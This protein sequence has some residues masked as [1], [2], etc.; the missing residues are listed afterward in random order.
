MNMAKDRLKGRKTLQVTNFLDEFEKDDIKKDVDIV[1]LFEHFGVNLT[2]K[3]KSYM[4]SCPW[5]ED[6]TPSLSVDRD[7]GLYNCFGCGESGDIFS[8]T[9]KMKGLNFRESVT[10]LKDF[11]GTTPGKIAD[12]NSSTNEDIPPKNLTASRPQ[13]EQENNV[14]TKDK[15][16]STSEETRRDAEPLTAET[17]EQSTSDDVSPTAGAMTLHTVTDYYHKRLFDNPKALDYLKNRG[18]ADTKLFTRFQIG[19]ADGTI[20]EKLTDTQKQSLKQQGIITAKD[21]EHFNDCVTI[22]IFDDLDT[23]VG[24]YG[25]SINP[26]AKIPHLYLKGKH[27]SVFN[28][29]AS[30]VYDEI[31]LTESIVDALS[32]ISLGFENTQSI[33]GTNGFTDEHLTILKDDRVKTVICAFDNDEAGEKASAKLKEQ[34]ANEGFVVKIISLPQV[35]NMFPEHPDSTV[36]DWNEYLTTGGTKEKITK[37]IDTADVFTPEQEDAHVKAEKDTLGHVFTINDIA[38]RVTG[39]KEL[40]I[41]NLRVNIK[42][43]DADTGLK[44]YDNLDLYSARSRSGYAG[45]MGRTLDIEPNR[46]EK[47]L[48]A[49]LEYL[50]TERDRH[51]KS[52]TGKEQETELTPEERELGL[53]FLKSPEMFAEIVE[54]MDV[55]GYVGE[56]LNKQL[57]YIAATSR[58]LDDPISVMVVS[59]SASGKSLLIDTIARLIPSD[60]VIS[61]TSL[62]EQALNYME[63][64]SHK[65][66]SLGEIVHSE[67]VEH[68]IREMLSKKELSRL[69]TTKEAQSGK[70]ITRMVKIPALVSLAMSGTRY[71]MNPENTSRCFMV[72]A[73]ESREQ[74]RRIH[75]QQWTKKYSVERKNE[76]KELIPE[77]I[78]KHHA[79]QK[80]LQPITIENTFGEYLDFPNTLMRTR[81][82]N[83]RFVDLIACVCFLRQYQKEQKYDANNEP[84]I[85]FDLIDYEIAYRIMTSGVLSSSLLEIPRGALDLY[86]YFRELARK[87]AKKENIEAREVSLTQREIREYTGLNQV[88]VK[89]HIKILLDYEYIA[90]ARGGKA[91]S[92]GHYQLREDVPMEEV[93]LSMIPTPEELKQKIQGKK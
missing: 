48:I 32:L 43:E 70:L 62:S 65:F 25:R 40:F 2:K 45:N 4:G 56:D 36:K 49:I 68:Q 61:V 26:K 15:K 42:A 50:E 58:K 44:Y 93:N 83:E 53:S 86:E 10:Y 57:M 74:T 29:K 85:A 17:K 27:R 38:Y 9:E 71:D 87:R 18:F 51:L 8:L 5:H 24:I 33:Y 60:E 30:K 41:S 47:D 90:L 54:D 19:F 34:L 39:A 31:I 59:E 69:V 52:S 28:R 35:P 91:R 20:I 7:K 22:P 37:A 79:A 21:R 78:Q 3:G 76:K 75:K 55:L 88:W 92:K 72:N 23:V 16:R 80:L 82:D 77:I 84:Y 13:D 64:L 81:R 14:E 6:T 63:D 11:A 73:D 46:I 12:L 89:R 1:R 66:L 67:V